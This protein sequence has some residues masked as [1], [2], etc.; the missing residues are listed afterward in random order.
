LFESDSD[1]WPFPPL[2]TKGKIMKPYR[3]PDDWLKSAR[4]RTWCLGL[5]SH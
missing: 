3:R 2:D 5:E 4:G 1:P